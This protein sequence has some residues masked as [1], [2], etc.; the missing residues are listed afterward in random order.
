MSVDIISS[1]RVVGDCSLIV[2]TREL[3]TFHE[4]Y[5]ECADGPKR[6]NDVLR[7]VAGQT[8]VGHNASSSFSITGQ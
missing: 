6:G 7:I 1:P 3:A 5:A 4:W 8:M 2:S